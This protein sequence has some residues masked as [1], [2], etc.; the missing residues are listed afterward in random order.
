MATVQKVLAEICARI[1]PVTK[2]PGQRIVDN[3]VALTVTGATNASPIV[4]TTSTVHGL[5]TGDKVYIT[6]VGGNTAANNSLTN[7][8]WTVTVTSTTQFSLDGSTGNGAYTSGGT[9]VPALVGSVD[10][11]KFTRQR[12]LQIY[13]D[14]RFVLF[15]AIVA[16]REIEG[17]SRELSDTLI[18]KTDFQFTLSGSVS[19]SANVPTGYIRRESLT[20]V[21]GD[22]IIVLDNSLILTIREGY[23]TTYD[24]SSTVRYAFEIGS[25]FVHYGTFVPSASTYVLHYYGLTTISI[26]DILGASVTEQW[27]D[28]KLWILYEIASAFAEGLGMSDVL[29]LAKKLITQE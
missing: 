22:P 24:Q 28:D 16:L 18:I 7:P 9:V 5:R 13:N 4:I 8:A 19:T 15:D 3:S 11:D 10:G 2:D 26:S 1:D 25:Q 12:Q 6:G 17:V 27:H 21:N 29:A 20:D 14:A 23:L